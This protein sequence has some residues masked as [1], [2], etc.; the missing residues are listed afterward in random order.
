MSP[1]WCKRWSI[2]RAGIINVYQYENETLHF[3]G[4]RLLLRAAVGRRLFGGSDI[5]Q[6]L[7]LLNIV[8]SPRVG[9]RVD[10][11]LPDHL[12]G[13]LPELSADAVAEAA[14]PLDHL[15]RLATL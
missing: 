12:V 4:G 3:G 9:D 7:R 10:V 15:I 1:A 6:H 14:R 13:A 11:E 2:C 5:D 8:R